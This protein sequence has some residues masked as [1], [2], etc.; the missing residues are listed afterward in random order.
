MNNTKNT[1]EKNMERRNLKNGK[2]NPKYVDLLEVDKPIAGQIYGC[3]SFITPEKILKQKEV[4]FFEEFLKKWDFSK[5]M[6]KFVQFLNFVSYKYKVSF[7]DVMK[8]YEEFVIEE[9]QNIVNSPIDGDYKTFLDN[10]EDELEK[11][12]NIQ[13]NFQTSVRGFKSRGNFGTQE[14]AELR[15]K[16]LREADPNFDIFVGPVGQWLCWDPEAYKTGRT[17]YLEEELNQLMSE[18]VKNETFAKN[19]FEQRIKDTKKKAIEENI[20]AAEKSGNTLTQ[21]IDDDGNLISIQ[22]TQEKTLQ[23][24]NSNTISVGDIRS[25]L[26]EGENIVIGKSDYGQSQLKSGPFA[27]KNK[28]E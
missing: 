7:E 3:Y 12:F 5:S 24:N 19:A 9:K 4:Y 16:L 6:E 22:N 26:F 2:P 17:E 8:D 20:K 21:T 23:E 14:E 28:K 25:E 27:P 1:T 11:K 10:N 13:H 15:A 18:K